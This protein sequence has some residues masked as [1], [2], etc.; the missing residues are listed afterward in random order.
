M[1]LGRESIFYCISVL[2]DSDSKR[3]ILQN[4][5]GFWKKRELTPHS[6]TG[7][8]LSFRNSHAEV[9]TLWEL[10]LILKLGDS[11][12]ETTAYFWPGVFWEV[13]VSGAACWQGKKRGHLMCISA[14]WNSKMHEVRLRHLKHTLWRR[15]LA[16]MSNKGTQAG[17][18]LAFG[19]ALLCLGRSCIG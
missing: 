9:H 10:Y 4:N 15:W 1:G 8:M 11:I 19:P 16:V 13:E 6:P 14:I 18:S 5:G 3:P 7:C 17:L 12:V 2:P